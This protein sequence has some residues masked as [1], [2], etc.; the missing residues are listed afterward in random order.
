MSLQWRRHATDANGASY[1]SLISYRSDDARGI[2]FEGN[3]AAALQDLATT[4]TERV[5]LAY[6]DPP[7]WTNRIFE[8]EFVKG[9]RKV[10]ER[11]RVT[12]FDD[13][14]P[15]LPAYL[16]ALEER[17]LAIRTLLAPHGSIVV[18]I[19][20]KTS[21]YVKVMCDGIFGMGAFA[22]EII[23]RYRRWPSK[24]P[25]YQR[26][27]DVLLRYRKDP[28]AKPRWNQAYEP[29]AAST[30]KTWGTRKQHAIV[31]ESG[32]RLRSSTLTEESAGVPLGDVWDIGVIAPI[33]NERTG[34][35]SQKPEALLARIIETLSDPNDLILDPYAGSGTTLAV[36]RKLGRAFIGIDESPVAIDIVRARMEA[37]GAPLLSESAAGRRGDARPRSADRIDPEGLP[38][39]GKE[40]HG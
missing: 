9:P 3:N 11:T 37:V 13:R 32:R 23:W 14:W 35:P 4:H 8:A 40:A 10:G 1:P 29:L 28:S 16:E 24:T 26:V 21:H 15:D 20:P 5:T 6:L 34:Y 33:A 19:D 2:L 39:R 17:L 7:F 27:H 25:N 38:E 22:S 18:H 31:G 30:K 36:A 12:A